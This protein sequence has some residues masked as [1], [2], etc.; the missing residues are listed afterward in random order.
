MT[1]E[2]E[3]YLRLAM[4]F[5]IGLM[6]GVERG[7]RG[8]DLPDGVRAAGIRTFTLIGFLGGIAALVDGTA[9]IIAGGAAVLVLLSAAYITGQDKNQSHGITSEVAA[10]IT[11]ILGVIAVRGDMAVAGAAAVAL[12]AVLGSRETVHGWLQKLER[13]ELKAAIQLLVISVIVLPVL[14]NQGYGPGGVINPFELWWMVV[15]I[16]GISFA[17]MAA[18]KL[19]GDRAGLFWAG[20]LGGL[21][22]STAVAVSYARLARETPSLTPA[23]TVGVGAATVLKFVRGLTIALI[24]FPAGALALAPSMLTAA[25]FTALAT[26]FMARDQKKTARSINAADTANGPD[27]MVAVSFAAVLAVVTLAEHFGREWFGATGVLV[28]AALSGLVDVDAVT[29]STARQALASPDQSAALLAMAVPIAVGVNT[30]AKLAYVS[31][32]AG[33]DMAK[34]YGVVALSAIAGLI[35]GTLLVR[36]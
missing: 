10:L 14:P 17:A 29:V 34:R 33:A 1:S 24:I 36:F 2:I 30:L 9:L 26:W 28:V 15:V 32:I 16:A 6:V 31:V 22:S 7:W 11:Y 18:T 35:L 13:V 27:L 4:A 19:L 5:G 21:A 3:I 20:L 12:V 25:A 23:L 8:R